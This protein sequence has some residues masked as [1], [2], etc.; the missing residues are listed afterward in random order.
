MEQCFSIL[1]VFPPLPVPLG[2]E[3]IVPARCR[4][5]VGLP[6]GNLLPGHHISAVRF[7]SRAVGGHRLPTIF[8]SIKKR[9]AAAYTPDHM[10]MN[11]RDLCRMYQR[12]KFQ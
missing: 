3:N 12:L 2:I 5:A 7:Q 1:S 6:C 9:V 10:T 8:V 4:R 11:T